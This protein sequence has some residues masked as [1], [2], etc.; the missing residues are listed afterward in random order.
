MA[1]S[2]ALL[3]ATH[4]FSFFVVAA[5]G[6]WLLA[7]ARDARRRVA[8]ALGGAAAAGA[9]VL[10][11]ALSQRAAGRTAWIADIPLGDRLEDAVKHFVTGPAGAPGAALGALAFLLV[12]ASAWLLLRR[13]REPLRRRALVA[14]GVGAIALGA[15]LLFTLAGA[16]Y[17]FARNLIG[18]W[19]LVAS[20]VAAGFAAP[21][22]RWAPAG[23]AALTLTLAAVTISVPLREESH[24][25]DWR[26]A[27]RVL[28]EAPA[29]RAI[30]VA[31][32]WYRVPVA[33]YRRVARLVLD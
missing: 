21:G 1:V 19:P 22:G 18:A 20:V 32:G 10:P 5:E 30:V 14:G 23:A 24:R 17:F 2:A 29:P 27:G 28:G 16:D 13:A 7:R 4:Y 3:L 26:G 12:L 9:A 25:T 31:P 33:V 8:A 15:P 6:A 11:L